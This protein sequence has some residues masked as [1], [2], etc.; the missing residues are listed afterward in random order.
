MF[1]S[2]S[3]PASEFLL[4]N[5]FPLGTHPCGAHACPPGSHPWDGF[6]VSQYLQRMPNHQ[7]PEHAVS[8]GQHF[9][10]RFLDVPFFV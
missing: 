7:R 4:W 6:T 9:L 8:F 10:Q 1:L 2:A 3:L 5:H